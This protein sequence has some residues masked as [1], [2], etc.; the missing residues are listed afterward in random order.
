MGATA[1]AVAGDGWATGVLCESFRG[2]SCSKMVSN[3]VLMGS[4][5][6]VEWCGGTNMCLLIH[7]S[8]RLR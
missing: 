5:H 4:L 1:Y 3:S 6:V 8:L 7:M 2:A